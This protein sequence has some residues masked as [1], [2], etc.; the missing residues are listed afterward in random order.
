MPV[1]RVATSRINHKASEDE[2]VLNT[3]I[4][5]GTGLGT[6]FAPTW[7]LVTASK[8]GKLPW[9]GDDEKPGYTQ[10]YK[11]ILRERYS[12][13]AGRKAFEQVLG[14]NKVVVFTCYCNDP[15]KTYQQHR[16]HRYLLVEIFRKLA[17]SRG[18]EFEYVGEFGK[19]GK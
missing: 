7:D 12:G 17:E 9:D 5:S 8:S 11:T 1:L 10:K 14:S 3:T 19:Q 18:I 15:E 13:I 2:L 16:C 6:V 4:G